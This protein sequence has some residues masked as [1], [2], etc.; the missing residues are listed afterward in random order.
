MCNYYKENGEVPVCTHDC[1]ECMWHEED[2]SKRRII[3]EL[4]L[5]SDCGGEQLTDEQII[6]DIEQS[7]DQIGWSY[8][9][10]IKSIEII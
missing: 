10:S 7:A 3:V 1:E 8:D 6:D 9:Y 2:E 4:E 5:E